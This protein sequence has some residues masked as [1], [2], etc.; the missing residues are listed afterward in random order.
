M[1]EEKKRQVH[2]VLTTDPSGDCNRTHAEVYDSEADAVEAVRRVRTWVSGR[3]EYVLG[4]VQAA[5]EA[6]VS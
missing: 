2:L 6:E 4:V 1:N 3:A 5:Q